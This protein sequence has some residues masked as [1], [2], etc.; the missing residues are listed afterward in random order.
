M[1]AATELSA[2]VSH[3]A[4]CRAF[5]V[6][7]SA[8]YRRRRPRETTPS[9]GMDPRP[10]RRGLS[11]EERAAVL[12][13]LNAERFVDASAAEVYAALLDEGVYLCSIS[14][15]YRHVPHPARSAAGT[16]EA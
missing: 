7:R 4:A 5:E 8:F 6:A 11:S 10:V 12:E 16:G 1:N 14:T 2:H 15:M 13:T 3:S 9:M